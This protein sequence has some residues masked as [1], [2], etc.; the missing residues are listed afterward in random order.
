[1]A[2]AAEMPNRVGTI[3]RVQRHVLEQSPGFKNRPLRMGSP[4]D[5]QSKIKTGPNS[6]LEILFTDG[7][8]M[9]L[10]E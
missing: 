1:M 9:T 6:R 3:S 2:E 10:G 4:V 8:K 7:S 5:A